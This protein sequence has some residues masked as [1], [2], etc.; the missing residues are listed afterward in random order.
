MQENQICELHDRHKRYVC[1]SSIC[2]NPKK[3]L[4][5]LCIKCSHSSCPD[6]EILSIGQFIFG[7]VQSFQNITKNKL[8][9]DS[10]NEDFLFFKAQKQY[11]ATKVNEEKK[12]FES[13]I[14]DKINFF[15]KKLRN[16]F[17]EIRE[18][19][20]KEK[21]IIQKIKLENID[22]FRKFCNL[23]FDLKEKK[24]HVSVKNSNKISKFIAVSNFLKNDF[25]PKFY[26]T[27]NEL[28]Q[29]NLKQKTQ[30][31][32]FISTSLLQ[33]NTKISKF[34]EFYNDK[35]KSW[36]NEN[37]LIH[38]IN[39]I[40]IPLKKCSFIFEIENLNFK[41]NNMD[42]LI[43]NEKGYDFWSKKLKFNEKYNFQTLPCLGKFPFNLEQLSNFKYYCEDFPF[44]KS[45]E[46]SVKGCQKVLEKICVVV[47]LDLSDKSLLILKP[48]GDVIEKIKIE[49]SLPEQNKSDLISIKLDAD[50]NNEDDE[51]GQLDNDWEDISDSLTNSSFSKSTE[52]EELEDELYTTK[53]AREWTQYNEKEPIYLGFHWH[54]EYLKTRIQLINFKE[55]LRK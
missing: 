48:N 20:L 25:T 1:L 11:N 49:S 35:L 40:S 39:L 6:D 23:S 53:Q 36:Y 44:K 4:C 9:N 33:T 18:D 45:L 14:D 28:L 52:S 41:S 2:T 37:G 42:I 30:Q 8:K 21:E 43:L 7:A 34:T 54:N 19:A 31:L 50:E 32:S 24:L 22:D 17:L 5:V 15:I 12:N 26:K 10:K 27:K 38:Q 55:Y 16:N 3:Y 51:I 47:Q 29:F 13:L 46:M